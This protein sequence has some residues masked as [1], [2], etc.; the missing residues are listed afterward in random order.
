MSY[1][2]CSNNWR[3][4]NNIFSESDA[5]YS[6]QNTL[7]NGGGLRIPKNAEVAVQSVK[8]NKNGDITVSPNSRF[9]L[10]FGE[11]VILEDNETIDDMTSYPIDIRLSTRSEQYNVEE[12]AT[13]VKNKLNEHLSHP[14]AINCQ[15]VTVNRN[16]SNVLLGLKF[17]LKERDVDATNG[18]GQYTDDC[19]IAYN[20][21]YFNTGFTY[22]SSNGCLTAGKTLPYDDSQ[23]DRQCILP[24]FS[25]A[26]SGN[27]STP[28]RVANLSNCSD[29]A[30]GLI[31]GSDNLVGGLKHPAYY[32]ITEQFQRYDGAGIPGKNGINMPKDF[33]FDYVVCAMQRVNTQGANR[34]LRVYQAVVDKTITNKQDALS[35]DAPFKMVEVDYWNVNDNFATPYNWSTNASNLDVVEFRFDGEEIKLYIGDRSPA[36]IPMIDEDAVGITDPTS[37]NLFKPINQC[38]W[39]LYPKFYLPRLNATIPEQTII[40]DEV[41]H[42]AGDEVPYNSSKSWWNRCVRDGLEYSLA[43]PVDCRYMNII[44]SGLEYAYNNTSDHSN[45]TNVMD[46]YKFKII[47]APNDVYPAP[48]ANSMELLGFSGRPIASY[49]TDNSTNASDGGIILSNSTLPLTSAKSLFVRLNNFTQDSFNAAKGSK[50]KIIFHLPRFDNAGNDTG[51]GLYYEN[52]DRFY[53]KLNNTEEFTQNEFLLDIVDDDERLAKDL[54]GKT[55]ICLHIQK[56]KD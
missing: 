16:A 27:G 4:N 3:E 22:D 31:R 7:S 50:S 39:N 42:I 41:P 5:P 47:T 13:L 36:N 32:D 14:L 45:L 44:Y 26:P 28:F 29:W 51:S 11:E 19:M 12:F 17:D 30:V 49:D 20:Q 2:I 54:T 8:I 38:C 33:Y 43:R 23:F 53:I 18:R 35:V 21:D 46:N 40:I 37:A 25:I 34:W 6:F 10:Y 9:S 48:L 52:Q 56:S 55:I 15:D 24:T 1:V